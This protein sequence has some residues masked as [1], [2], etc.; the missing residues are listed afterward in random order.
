MLNLA[1]MVRLMV[2][3][4]EVVPAPDNDESDVGN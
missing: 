4:L 1:V 3:M 2:H